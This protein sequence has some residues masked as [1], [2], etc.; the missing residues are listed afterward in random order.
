MTLNIKLRAF[1]RREVQASKLT[2][3]NFGGIVIRPCGILFIIA[4][5][6]YPADAEK[7]RQETILAGS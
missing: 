1:G 7:V 4:A 2:V 6:S 3:V 5:R